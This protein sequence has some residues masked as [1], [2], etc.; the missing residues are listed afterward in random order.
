[1]QKFINTSDLIIRKHAFIIGAQ[2]SGTSYLAEILA[3]SPK[4]SF[5]EPRFP[6]PKF[7]LDPAKIAKGKNFYKELYFTQNKQV[8]VFM[9][10]STSYLE[11]PSVAEK[12]RSWFPKTTI[13][14][15][16]RN[17]VD[18][19]ISNYFFSKANAL[20]SRPIEEALADDKALPSVVLKKFSAS[21]FA[22][23]ERGFYAQQLKKWEKYFSRRQI[24]I[25]LFENIITSK[26]PVL[27]LYCSL[28][29]SRANRELRFPNT[30]INRGFNYNKNH[31]SPNTFSYLKS[32]FSNSVIELDREWNVGAAKTWG[33]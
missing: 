18:R 1:M 28:T 9:E 26:E 22:Y 23:I 14:V 24:K 21:P 7:F 3:S 4:I 19:A 8:K 30:P 29:N 13:I 16:L 20:E 15:L 10:K 17:P 25:L 6:E 32:I 2:R 11:N 27:N 31:I 12:I 5:A 33:F